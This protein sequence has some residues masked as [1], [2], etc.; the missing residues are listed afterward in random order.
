IWES[1]PS[2][3]CGEPLLQ[4]AFRIGGKR[5]AAISDC[6]LFELV[7]GYNASLSVSKFNH[8]GLA[9]KNFVAQMELAWILGIRKL[10]IGCGYDIGKENFDRGFARMRQVTVVGDNDDASFLAYYVVQHQ[11]Q[12]GCCFLSKKITLSPIGVARQ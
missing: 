6:V 11:R 9:V 7:L 12:L 10:R 1:G 2:I 3:A 4:R 8:N 5:D